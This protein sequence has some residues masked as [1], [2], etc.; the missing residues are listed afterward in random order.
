MVICI[1]MIDF[2]YHVIHLQDRKSCMIVTMLLFWDMLDITKAYSKVR[3][4]FYW[5]AL[6]R[7]VRRYVQECLQC[8]QVKVEQH[9][10]P[11]KMQPLDIPFRK[12]ESI[13]MDFITKL[14]TARG[15]YDT[16]FVVV[17]RLTKM[18]H[19]FPMKKTHDALEVAKLFV[20]KIS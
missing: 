7:D 4:S 12:W 15:G 11:G 1:A 13:S 14:P 3:K 16:I 6:K 18:A 20:K 5:P 10:M 19:F 8:Q 2:A 17:D 9:K